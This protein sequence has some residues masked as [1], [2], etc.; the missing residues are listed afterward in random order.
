M[1][2]K[3]PFLTLLTFF[4][5]STFYLPLLFAQSPLLEG[6]KE[7]FGKG[8]IYDVKY[9][10]DGTRLAVASS[11]GIWIYDA[12][13]YQLLSFLKEYE[14][15]LKRIVFSPDG[16]IIAGEAEL[17][18][19]HLW[20]VNTGKHKYELMRQHWVRHF[21]FSADGKTL[22]TIG[23]NDD[24][25]FWHTDTGVK[26]QETKSLEPMIL[27]NTY[28]STFDM[29]NFTLAI[30]DLNNTIYLWDTVKGVQKKALV[31][32]TD[33]PYCLAFSPDG[34][35]LASGSGDRTLR[36]WDIAEGKQRYIFSGADMYSIESVAF[37]PDGGLLAGGDELGHIH[38]VG[39]NTDEYKKILKGHSEEVVA[40]TFNPDMR[41]VASGSKDGSVR[42]WDITSGENK[43]TL[44]GY[45]DAFTSFDVS[46][47]GKTIVMAGKDSNICLW[48]ATSG[49]LEKT[50][51]KE[52]F[53]RKHGVGTIAFS[54]DGNFIVITN[55]GK[56]LW[57][58]NTGKPMVLFLQPGGSVWSVAFSPDGKTMVVGGGDG[59]IQLLDMD[60]RG[61]QKQVIA[62]HEERVISVAYS[63]DGKTI[64]SGSAD[65]TIKLWD[66]NTTAEKKVFAG[67][68]NGLTDVALSSDGK[69]IAAVDNT[70]MIYLWDVET[71]TQKKFRPR[72][73]EGVLSVAFSPNGKRLATGDID[74]AVYISG[75]ESGITQQRFT[76]HA[77][78]VKRVAFAADG[79]VLVSLSDDGVILLWDVK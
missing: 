30:G 4:I 44:D 73:A 65:K 7:W 62:A 12:A 14:T 47:D 53:H 66:A 41:T 42:I 23:V 40:I 46:L 17:S 9:S 1:I 72:H 67:H 2:R 26:K 19:I 70:A 77:G 38:L 31:G 24:L 10:P 13:T 63:P 57:D 29:N 48:D 79:K 11:E 34:K 15:D 3:T 51:A 43:L 56:F 16:N 5:V 33:I 55:A 64:I 25:T 27:I 8:R 59:T 69:T 39:P 61:A 68:A 78:Q 36:V 35:T 32:H 76:G 6:A 37:S 45:F 21:D 18:R 49:K 71:G 20:D 28:C 75:T 74:G 22:V 58:R 52:W 60:R 50:F 54:Q